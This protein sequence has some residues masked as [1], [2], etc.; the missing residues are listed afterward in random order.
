VTALLVTAVTAAWSL[1]T[2]AQQARIPVIGYLNT[3]SSDAYARRVATFRR[4]LNESG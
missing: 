2:R 4:G 1:T 3:L